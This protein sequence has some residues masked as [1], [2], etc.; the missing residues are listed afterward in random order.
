MTFGRRE[1]DHS[2]LAFRA[3]MRACR[4]AR[5]G[6]GMSLGSDVS[7]VAPACATAPGLVTGPVA[8]LA[9]TAWGVGAAGVMLADSERASAVDG[10]AGEA[11]GW[12]AAALS[13]PAATPAGLSGGFV[14]R[15]EGCL[16]DERRRTSGLSAAEV[17]AGS[18]PGLGG[19]WLAASRAARIFCVGI[20]VRRWRMTGEEALVE[21]ALALAAEAV[22]ASARRRRMNWSRA[23]FGTLLKVPRSSKQPS[24]CS[25]HSSVRCARCR[26]RKSS[27]SCACTSR[28][29]PRKASRSSGSGC[30]GAALAAA[31]LTV[32]GSVMF[33]SA[34]MACSAASWGWCN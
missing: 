17:P 13:A 1:A 15:A 32:A 18:G 19:A 2:P 21:G 23:A 33:A 9:G 3:L 8:G 4:S 26:S 28:S 27:S 34:A 20:T 25:R 5:N 6:T 31:A 10:V 12:M 30:P 16:Q 29:W 24:V 7:F 22:A 14:A 11:T